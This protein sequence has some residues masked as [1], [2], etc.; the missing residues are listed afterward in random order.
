VK[1]DSPMA[2]ATT[3]SKKSGGYRKAAK[4]QRI[5]TQ[6]D[7]RSVRRDEKEQLRESDLAIGATRPDRQRPAK[8][9]S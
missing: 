9:T 3:K 6:G 1:E 8:R 2:K 4:R 7:E 5:D